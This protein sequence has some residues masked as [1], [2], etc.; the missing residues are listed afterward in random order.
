MMTAS[1]FRYDQADGGRRAARRTSG[2]ATRCC[3]ACC[4]AVPPLRR[5]PD[6]GLRLSTRIAAIVLN[7][8]C[9]LGLVTGFR[10]SPDAVE[11]EAMIIASPFEEGALNK[12]RFAWAV[13]PTDAVV[14]SRVS[15]NPILQRTGQFIGENPVRWCGG[16]GRI[17]A[18]ATSVADP[19]RA[20]QSC[21]WR[22]VRKLSTTK[23]ATS[24]PSR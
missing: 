3:S 16:G 15:Q 21:G 19:R 13:H 17:P 7:E 12:R 2:S 14:Q 24:L 23:S 18:S 22:D 6:P 4:A 10:A 5:R 9:P 20:I 8:N 11:G 1:S